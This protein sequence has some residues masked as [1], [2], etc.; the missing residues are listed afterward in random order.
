MYRFVVRC[1]SEQMIEKNRPIFDNVA[2]TA[3]K[4]SKNYLKVQNFYNQ[5]LLNIDIIIANYVLEFF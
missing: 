5:L 1:Q 2:K 3:A 4:L